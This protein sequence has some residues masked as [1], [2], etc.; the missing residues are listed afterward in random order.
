MIGR[1]FKRI[2][3]RLIRGLVTHPIRGVIVLAAVLMATGV[4]A[5]Q[6]VD[7]RVL[8]GGWQSIGLP[9]IGLPSFGSRVSGAPPSATESYMKGTEMFNA[10]M[11]WSSL[12]EEALARYRTRGGNVQTMQAQM[13]QARQAGNQVAEITYIGGQALPDGT[14]LHFYSVF[15]RGAQSRT[16]GE[17]VPYVFTVDRSGKIS[18]VQ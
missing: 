11:V 16:E 4:L 10:E 2:F 9:N 7:P 8:S 18:R 12:S 13:D 3:H 6:S 17:H 1:I 5:A 15:A 14:S